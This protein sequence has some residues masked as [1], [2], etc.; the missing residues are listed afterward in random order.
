MTRKPSNHGKP[1]TQAD[2][3]KIGRL[4]KQ[5]KDTPQIAKELGR[6]ESSVRTKAS[7]ENKSLKPNDK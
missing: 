1:W 3:N 7:E 5:G 2:I 6:T 4:A